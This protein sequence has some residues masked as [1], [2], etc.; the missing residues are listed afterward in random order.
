MN[1]DNCSK[2]IQK[3]YI[4]MIKKLQNRVSN[5]KPWSANVLHN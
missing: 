1:L 3:F 5:L 2:K 4:S